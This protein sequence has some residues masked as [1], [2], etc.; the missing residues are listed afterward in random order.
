MSDAQD[1][2]PVL[3]EAMEAAQRIVEHQPNKHDWGY[4]KEVLLVARAL[5]SLRSERDAVL[6]E[7]AK[8]AMKA[9]VAFMDSSPVSDPEG[10]LVSAIQAIR[11]LK[12]NTHG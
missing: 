5:L 12:E 9:G 3:D 10:T 11:A 2:P 1:L 4:T 8:V 6:E 7:A